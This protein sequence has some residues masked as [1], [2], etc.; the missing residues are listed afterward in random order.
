MDRVVYTKASPKPEKANSEYDAQTLAWL[1]GT[2]SQI[3]IEFSRTGKYF[4]DD[5]EE[6]D[7]YSV[8]LRRGS[9]HYTFTFGQSLAASEQFKPDPYGE[10]VMR[11]PSRNR[12]QPS[13]YSILSC[14]VSTNPGVFEEWCGEFGYDTDSR[15]AEK[16]WRACV[17]QYLKLDAMYTRE[18]L[19]ALGE[20]N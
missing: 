19:N 17:E 12:C 7:I 11:L 20:I 16:T 14:L 18:E 4:D 2:N 13:A 3:E 8:T 6:R 1:D 10:H 9:D 15:K 5:K